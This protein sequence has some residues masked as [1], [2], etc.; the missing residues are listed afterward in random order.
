MYV[1][2]TVEIL[3]LIGKMSFKIKKKKKGI[4][5]SRKVCEAS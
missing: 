2:G 3:S 5:N 1:L 4:N